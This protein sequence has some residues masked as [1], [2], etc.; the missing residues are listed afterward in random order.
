MWLA[1]TFTVH[2]ENILLFG[3]FFQFPH[4]IL[5]DSTEYSG[6]CFSFLQSH[7]LRDVSVLRNYVH[8][9]KL[10]LP[11]NKIKGDILFQ[12]YDLHLFIRF[13]VSLFV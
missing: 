10:E 9:Q 5:S 11:H 13:A 1:D 4:E 3:H 12:S 2:T 7:N 8:L 6:L